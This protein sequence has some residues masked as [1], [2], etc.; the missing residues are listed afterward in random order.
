MKER[1]VKTTETV[2]NNFSEE[3]GE[4]KGS[5]KET[6]SYSIFVEDSESFAYVFSSIIGALKN[7]NGNDVLLLTYCS[8]NAEFNTNRITI[9]KPICD[10]IHE[11]LG[12]PYQSVKNSLGKMTKI[13]IF[14]RLGSGSYLIN[15]H[16]YW[17]GKRNERGK[18]AKEFSISV[19][20]KPNNNFENE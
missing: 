8:L 20:I 15:P 12:V 6:K 14:Q 16:Y 2:T 18:V 10:E 11:K 5:H 4:L 3:T 1:H 9:N 7:L 17:R 19:K 13:G